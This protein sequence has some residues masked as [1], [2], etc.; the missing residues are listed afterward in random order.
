MQSEIQ[1]ILKKNWKS[2]VIQGGSK[3]FKKH[4]VNYYFFSIIILIKMRWIEIYIKEINE[5]TFYVGLA[6]LKIHPI[7]PNNKRI[8]PPLKVVDKFPKDCR[9]DFLM[10]EEIEAVKFGH[11]LEEKE[12]SLLVENFEI[13]LR[14]GYKFLFFPADWPPCKLEIEMQA[15]ESPKLRVVK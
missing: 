5:D 3:G 6:L 4:E 8:N 1:D 2:V 7:D 15:P 14:N 13:T 12:D 11:I 9:L 10:S